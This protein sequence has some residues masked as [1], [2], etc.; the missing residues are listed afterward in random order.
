M[1]STK[2]ESNFYVDENDV[3]DDPANVNIISVKKCENVTITLKTVVNMWNK[4]P[5][6]KTNREMYMPMKRNIWKKKFSLNEKDDDDEKVMLKKQLKQLHE[7]RT[8]WNLKSKENDDE[9]IK[10]KEQ[11][12]KLQKDCV[13]LKN[14]LQESKLHTSKHLERSISLQETAKHHNIINNNHL[15][16]YFPKDK[17]GI[18]YWPIKRYK[19]IKTSGLEGHFTV[20]SKE[21]SI[22]ENG[23]KFIME[24]DLNG[25]VFNGWGTHLSV[26]IFTVVSHNDDNLHWP[27]CLSGIIGILDISGKNQIYFK[28]FSCTVN[29]SGLKE[30]I[31]FPQ[32]IPQKDLEES[33]YLTDDTLTLLAM[34]YDTN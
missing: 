9:I 23:Y 24:A 17:I 21:F 12:S 27:C 14:K 20:I 6:I 30:I 22:G 5:I 15:N 13:I 7:E 2:K 18:L 26:R 34:I 11:I 33:S 16:N 32:F 3:D 28:S 29:N 19:K 25:D 10:L 31:A 1:Q 4:L 8:A